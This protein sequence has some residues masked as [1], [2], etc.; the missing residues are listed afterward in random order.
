SRD[1]ALQERLSGLRIGQTPRPGYRVSLVRAR[2]EDALA[3][4]LPS[5]RQTVH[6]AGAS[7]V[8]VLSGGQSVNIERI[9]DLAAGAAID[10]MRP[11]YGGLDL[12]PVG[13][14]EA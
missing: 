4:A 6:W 5:A 1:S 7:R 10:A 12:Q 13:K 14:L 9:T 11:V 2:V 3:R 8:D